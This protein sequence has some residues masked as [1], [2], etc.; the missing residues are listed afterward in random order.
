MI[1][2][3]VDLGSNSF[4]MTVAQW[5]PELRSGRPF[6]VLHKERHAVQLGRSVFADGRMSP[7]ARK[8]ALRALD[9]MNVRLKDFGVPVLRVVAT[10]A[11]REAADGR[12][13]VEEVRDRIGL[14]IEIITDDQEF[15]HEWLR[16]GQVLGCVTSLG[17]A[18]RGCPV[19]PLGVM[20]YVAVA[21]RAFV[22]AHCP[23]GLTAHNFPRLPFLAFNRKDHLQ[24]EFVARAFGLPR[25]MLKQLFVPSSEGQ[26][27]AARA[28]WGITVVPELGVREALGKGE[29]VQLLPRHRLGVTLHWHCWNLQSE[30][31]QS[32]TEA[33]REA[34]SR[35]L[36]PVAG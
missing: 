35:V 36:G 30:V 19:E 22:E 26:I 17:Q 21:S 9:R 29:L 33:L 7:K 4:K 24:H 18:L 12:D 10:S 20:D 13:F 11:I 6:R 16:E 23:Q 5:V 8:A 1:L 15:T 14:P 31:L 27:R 28:G 32:L 25:V 3:V 34:A 2:A